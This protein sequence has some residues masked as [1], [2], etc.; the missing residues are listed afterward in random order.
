M[1]HDFETLGFLLLKIGILF[2]ILTK[3]LAVFPLRKPGSYLFYVV[4]V[5]LMMGEDLTNLL[6]EAPTWNLRE[7][8]KGTMS[9]FVQRPT[10]LET[11]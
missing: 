2:N 11:D 3:K 8:E 10:N 4:I 9:D 6:A 5:D 7:G 1:A